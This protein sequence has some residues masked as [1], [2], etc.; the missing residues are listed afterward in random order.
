MRLVFLALTLFGVSCGS[1]AV[2]TLYRDSVSGGQFDPDSQNAR[3]HVASFDSANGNDYNWE[4]CTVARDL[5]QS[6]DGV[7]IKFWC[8]KGRYRK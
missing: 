8:E 2:A 7:K 4:N 6:Q 1:G 5:F 3:I